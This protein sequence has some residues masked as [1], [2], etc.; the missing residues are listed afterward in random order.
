MLCTEQIIRK[1]NK[2][3][4]IFHRVLFSALASTTYDVII[5]WNGRLS[6]GIHHLSMDPQ[7][8]LSATNNNS[9]QCVFGVFYSKN[10]ENMFICS[11][12]YFVKIHF[13]PILVA[14]KSVRD[15]NEEH[16]GRNTH[17]AACTLKC[18]A[19]CFELVSCISTRFKI[20]LNEK[21]LIGNVFFRMSTS[22]FI[23][24]QTRTHSGI[25]W[26]NTIKSTHIFISVIQIRI[27]TGWKT[28]W[29]EAFIGFFLK[30]RNYT[31]R[32]F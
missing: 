9:Y 7:F 29:F 14:K 32:I 3:L 18:L 28:I 22:V 1:I 19:Q 11:H 20:R 26:M 24:N 30:K 10:C 8:W 25:L 4:N 31:R 16:D 23:C 12:C 2:G 6:F 27:V 15:A 17:L 21:N 5:E 13:H